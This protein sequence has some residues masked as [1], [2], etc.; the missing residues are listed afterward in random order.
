MATTFGLGAAVAYQ[1]VYIVNLCV[2]CFHC[3]AIIDCCLTLISDVL[4]F[5]TDGCINKSITYKKVKERIA[6]NG[7][8]S[9]SYGTSIAIWDHTVLPATR[10]K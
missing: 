10:H 6:V 9:H 7:T 1:L 5:S 2:D 8:P 4:Y 3:C